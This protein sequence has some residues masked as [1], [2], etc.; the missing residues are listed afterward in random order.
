MRA[1]WI[2]WHNK[3]LYEL[4]PEDLHR[5]KD[6]QVSESYFV[7]YKRQWDPFK[8]ARSIASFANTEG[9]TVVV[10]VEDQNM[11]PVAVEGIRF[12]GNVL[13]SLDQAVR[14]HVTPVP[15]YSSVT[16]PV[17]DDRFCLV[18]EVPS[19]YDTPYVLVNTGQILER[20]NTSSDPV[21]PH[22]RERIRELFERGKSGKSWADQVVR[23]SLTDDDR[24]D[25]LKVWT[26]P[27]IEGG[28]NLNAVLYLPSFVER[29]LDLAPV[30][31]A[32]SSW[33]PTYETLGYHLRIKHALSH[34]CITEIG[35]DGILFTGWSLTKDTTWIPVRSDL[36]PLPIEEEEFFSFNDVREY[37]PTVLVG[38]HALL[39]ELVGYTGPTTLVLK[40]IFATKR[41]AAAHRTNVPTEALRT[42][43]F[44]DAILRDFDRALGQT[45]L[46]PED[47]R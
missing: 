6:E 5:L 17:A 36:P 40:A 46:E 29:A 13:E 21:P 10:G 45:V 41:S 27:Q 34:Q 33:N 14:R 9:G 15:M 38:H 42:Q 26:I 24:P 32:H 43:G 23:D 35:L 19:G 11:V 18:I 37:V 4:S 28:L 20:S 1:R 12:T 39:H 47:K 44:H 30:P 25:H 8:V 16:V 31:F 2:P 22:N 3:G 7:E